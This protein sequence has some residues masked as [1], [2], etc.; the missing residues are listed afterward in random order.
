MKELLKIIFISK[1]VVP[2]SSLQLFFLAKEV[3]YI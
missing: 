2:I 3:E 1:F